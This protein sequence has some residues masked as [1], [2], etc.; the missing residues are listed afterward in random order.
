MHAMRVDAVI[1]G[2]GPAGLSAALLLGRCR[3]N[4]VVFDDRNYR[5]RDSRQIHGFLTRDRDTSPEDLRSLARADLAAY[6][7]VR[8]VHE[9]VV[10]ARRTE[11]G[12]AVLTKSGEQLDCRAL[13]LATGFRDKLPPIAGARELHGDRVVPCPYCDAWEVRD[14]P[15]A[16]FSHPDD[17]G[18]AFA[19]ALAQWSGDV[20]LCAER[21]PV[22]E[23]DQLERLARRGVRVEQRE[24][25]TVEADGE[26]VRLVFSEG[27][28]LWRRRLFYHLGGEPVSNL[29]QRLGADVEDKGGAVVDRTQQTPIPGL[30]VAGDATRDALQ[31]IVGAGE[32]AGAA[33]AINEHLCQRE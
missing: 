26:G 10:D 11:H 19:A 20:V 8:I 24:L 21:R 3:R 4:V 15:L 30:F 27:D 5:N 28:P 25:R 12:F 22:I 32:G 7:T 16:A 33:I 18:A 2:G 31:A 13:L 6:P 23:A 29:A 1:V 17:R 14:Q 9:T